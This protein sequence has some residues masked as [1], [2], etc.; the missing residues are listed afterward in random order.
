M[1]GSRALIAKTSLE[2]GGLQTEGAEGKL[3]L[4]YVS[5]CCTR[6]QV[7]CMST[8]VKMCD[9]GFLGFLCVSA[10]MCHKLILV[11]FLSGQQQLLVLRVA[12]LSTTEAAVLRSVTGCCVMGCTLADGRTQVSCHCASQT[13]HCSRSSSCCRDIALQVC[14]GFGTGQQFGV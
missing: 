14:F 12:I 11:M 13:T 6:V 1:R 9:A 4:V 10:P 8:Q 3:L 2:S 7:E 5:V